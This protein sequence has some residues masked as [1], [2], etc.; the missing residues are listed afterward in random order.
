MMSR[1]IDKI[2]NNFKLVFAVVVIVALS[3]RLLI[4]FTST[5]STHKAGV[6]V[7][8]TDIAISVLNKEEFSFNIARHSWISDNIDILLDNPISR[9]DIPDFSYSERTPIAYMDP[10]YSIMVGL[11]SK[12]TNSIINWRLIQ[13][14][15][16]ICDIL[17][18][19]IIYKVGRGLGLPKLISLFPTV[20]HAFNFLL[21]R[22]VFQL[23]QD[24]FV[25]FIVI[26][27]VW[28]LILKPKH[29]YSKVFQYFFIFLL[30]GILPWFRSFYVLFPLF[31]FF[32]V[33][34]FI[35]IKKLPKIYLLIS[36][37]FF[38]GCIT[39][40]VAPRY[41]ELSQQDLSFSFGR[42]GCFW[43]PFYV[44][45]HQFDDGPTGDT[46]GM[47]KALEIYP[48]LKEQPLITSWTKIDSLMKDVVISEIKE[49]PTKYM[50]IS[51][52][53]LIIGLFPSF[54]SNYDNILKIPK[55]IIYLGRI[56]LFF[57]TTI[58]LISFYLSLRKSKY[59][60]GVLFLLPWFYI[61]L[62]STPFYLQGRSLIPAIDLIIV[63]FF[64]S[65]VEIKK[66]YF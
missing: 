58:V 34:F 31:V 35:A 27:S 13:L 40:Y 14:L 53:R 2:N 54:Y 50:L 30:G 4:F 41:I 33:L 19:F 37:L 20:V 47:A 26:V 22:T 36:I 56:I 59:Y 51:S 25:I 17:L 57:I 61:V 39:I 49:S 38:I 6:T 65:L 64:H 11:I 8:H 28:L 44:G 3:I 12:F 32:I 21:L 9:L 43:F 1:V 5:P 63:Y 24:F 46:L 18:L 23:V 16:I 55:P 10:G 66:Q 29:Q 42:P 45:L 7:S 15:Q 48:R 62:L 60:T 52:R